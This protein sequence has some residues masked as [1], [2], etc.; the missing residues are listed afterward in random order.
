MT[1]PVNTP[2]FGPVSVSCRVSLSPVAAL[3]SV[4][5]S[6][7]STP[8]LRSWSASVTCTNSAS[9]ACSTSAGTS[10]TGLSASIGV[11]SSA[12][13]SASTTKLL[14]PES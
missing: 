7:S 13:G 10:G 5:T 8:G 1:K 6:V 2:V 9:P 4:T 14:P 11:P 3:V 12:V